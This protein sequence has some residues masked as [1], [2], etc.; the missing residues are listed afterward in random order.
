[1]LLVITALLI[2]VTV[3]LA[4]GRVGVLADVRL[5]GASLVAIA[6]GAQILV[7]SVFPGSLD[8]LHE[9]VHLASYLLLGVFMWLNRRIPGMLLVAAGGTA[10][11]AAIFANGGV[12]PASAEAL[13]AAGMSPEKAGE[14]ANSAVV[15]SP[16]LSWL[17]DV[18][19]VPAAWPASNVFSVGD[20]LIAVG[21][22][23]AL[24]R[25]AGSRLAPAARL[26]RT[27]RP[28]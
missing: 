21:L 12:M 4:G 14:Y 8:G 6:L 25:L 15:E 18:F 23:V 7:V 19:A 9:P 1:M 10:N 27:P 22:A 2:L 13:A 16:A 3:P 17:G 28:T 5:R 20:V 24:H 26:R 11:A